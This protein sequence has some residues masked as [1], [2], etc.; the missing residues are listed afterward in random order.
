VLSGGFATTVHRSNGKGAFPLASM[1]VDERT[2]RAAGFG[3][4]ASGSVRAF[5]YCEPSP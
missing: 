1:R 4:G 5:A 2:W 3:N